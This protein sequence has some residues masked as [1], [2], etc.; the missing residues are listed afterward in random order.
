MLICA[1]NHTGKSQYQARTLFSR[2]HTY[3]DPTL[4]ITIVLPLKPI[5]SVLQSVQHL[6]CEF[7]F[8]CL[9]SSSFV[10]KTR[11]SLVAVELPVDSLFACRI[12]SAT[13]TLKE[14]IETFAISHIGWM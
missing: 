10:H 1:G 5:S 12:D 6:I 11:K 13:N 4:T 7:V 2:R 14:L 8:I 3:S 9:I